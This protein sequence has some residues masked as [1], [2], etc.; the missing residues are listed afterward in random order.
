[1]FTR[2]PSVVTGYAFAVAAVAVATLLRFAL[3]PVLGEGVPFILD[4]PTVVLCAWF[5][6]LWPGLL[7]AA[8]S[9]LVAWYVFI[10]PA[11]SF[12][13]SDPTAPAQLIVYLFASCT[14]RGEKPKR[15]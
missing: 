10:P 14:G 7:C 8:L 11:Y 4:F 2:N 9:G 5:G 12:A 6:G 1:M 3:A 15:A 13:V